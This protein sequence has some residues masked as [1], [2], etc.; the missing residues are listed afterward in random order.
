MN[1]A[2]NTPGGGM[3]GYAGTPANAAL[4]FSLTTLG[5]TDPYGNTYPSGLA[6]ESGLLT[7]M[8]M[9]GANL[10]STSILQG[11]VLNQGNINSPSIT[12]GLATSTL[13]VI[14][15]SGGGVYSYSQNS[16]TVTFTTSQAAGW[17]CPTGVTHVQ[18]QCWG[19]GAGGGGGG[20]SQGGEAGGGGE[21][22]SEPSLSVIPGNVYTI[23]VGAGGLG[24]QTGNA[25]ANGGNTIF[26]SNLV[27]ANGGQAGSGGNGGQGGSGSSNT[28]ENQGGNGGSNP[29]NVSGA[30][31]GGSSGGTAA[32]GNNGGNPSSSSG[33]AGGGAVTGGGAG[34]TGGA[35]A[36]N[37]SNGAAPGGGG[38]GA[39]EGSTYNQQTIN[40]YTTGTASYYGTQV[41]QGLRNTN[42]YMYQ[43]CASGDLGATGDQESFANYNASQMAS[44]WSGYTIDSQEI[45][46]YLAHSWYNSGCYCILGYAEGGTSYE[47][48]LAAWC[49]VGVTTT[50][51]FTNYG[52]PAPGGYAA[53]Q[54]GPSGATSGG[55][56]DLYNYGYFNGGTTYGPYLTI[57]GH[58]GTSGS[59]TA[60]NGAAGKMIITYTSTA[61]TTLQASISP[62][63]TTD[64]LGNSIPVGVYLANVSAPTAGAAGAVQ[65]AAS[66][67]LKYVASSDGN[68]YNT[69]RITQFIT[70][71]ITGSATTTGQSIFAG[72][73]VVAGSY[74]VHA[75]ITYNG[76]GTGNMEA[77][78]LGP[79]TSFC[80]VTYSTL[81]GLN[82]TQ[83]F[84][85]RQTAL[86]SFSGVTNALVNGD[87][88]VM[89]IH[90]MITFTAGGTLNVSFYESVH[91]TCNV[92]TG[93]IL[94][95]YPV[96]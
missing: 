1:F 95:V 12:G 54:F 7:G 71:G 81:G 28:I 80:L 91:P 40:Y 44:D 88:Y 74:R 15:T 68:A 36:A 4:S 94:D 32:N 79:S 86:N 23:T 73:P 24:G 11:S 70:T 75:V 59:Y 18:V 89:T 62:V 35:S 21:Y 50:I 27:F 16:T 20:T 29:S 65:Y 5:G 51:D 77:C 61:N 42:G 48:G 58:I 17:T 63:A 30:A 84:V 92:D 72:V 37:G 96:A 38:G 53:M 69:G 39:G 83:G 31:G 57:K 76:T 93:S 10:D 85:A 45:T 56:T 78:F 49:D 87:N 22:A 13:H 14:N 60:G 8:Q 64:S 67:Q 19:A 26:G 52:F 66:G 9:I 41:G 46:V 6:V 43:G 25:G 33:A 90:A 3:F 34:G 82:T 55:P 2:S 47:N